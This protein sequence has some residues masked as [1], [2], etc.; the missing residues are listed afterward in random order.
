MGIGYPK[1]RGRIVEKYG[2][3]MEFASEIGKTEQTVTAKLNGKS[4][5]T[6]DDIMEWSKALELSEAD[7]G[8]YFFAT[9]LSKS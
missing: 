9:E 7:V 2:S 4:K 8:T 3:Q 6:L 5:F 1:L